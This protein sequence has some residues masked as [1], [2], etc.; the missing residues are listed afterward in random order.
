MASDR[1]LPIYFKIDTAHPDNEQVLFECEDW[2]GR[3]IMQ[4]QSHKHTNQFEV[5][6][7]DKYVT[8]PRR[9]DVHSFLKTC[10]ATD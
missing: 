1:V 7:K 2:Y 4:T 8:Q 3:D 6:V 9:L 10:S 5:I